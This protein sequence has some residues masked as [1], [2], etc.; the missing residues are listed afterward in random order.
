MIEKNWTKIFPL[1]YEEVVRNWLTEEKGWELRKKQP[2]IYYSKQKIINNHS[3]LKYIK[4]AIKEYN[5]DLKTEKTYFCADG[6][7][8]EP[9]TNRK[10]LIEAKSW[11][12]EFTP[13]GKLVN[14]RYALDFALSNIITVATEEPR[15]IEIDHYCLIFWSAEA[16]AA[17]GK[18]ES[19]KAIH[20]KIKQELQE[21]REN[22]S[23]EIIYL[24]ELWKI[25]RKNQPEWYI[26]IIKPIYEE[27]ERMFKWLLKND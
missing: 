27:I 23:F 17:D 13:S 9:K 15:D 18:H 1:F 16:D 4:E 5:Q 26:D 25:V 24:V 10:I 7:F 14:N 3:E 8:I 19:G 6:Y 21:V 12:P 11:V 2:R 22:K 20:N